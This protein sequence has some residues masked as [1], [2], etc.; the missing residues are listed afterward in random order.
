VKVV[1]GFY[2]KYHFW[3]LTQMQVST[4][5]I[6]LTSRTKSY[7]AVKTVTR[8]MPSQIIRSYP[9]ITRQCMSRTNVSLSSSLDTEMDHLQHGSRLPFPG[10]RQRKLDTLSI[11]VFEQ[12]GRAVFTP[13]CLDRTSQ[14]RSRARRSRRRS[15][16]RPN[17]SHTSEILISGATMTINPLRGRYIMA[18]TSR[19]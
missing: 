10:P 15:T 8:A 12:I 19:D 16:T 7:A 9:S 1:S 3:I 14:N 4:V 2:K 6:Q 11:N 5:C 18:V 17:R 13:Q